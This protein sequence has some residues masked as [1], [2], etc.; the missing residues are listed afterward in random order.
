VDA[1]RALPAGFELGACGARRALAGACQLH[2]AAR[3]A[4]PIGSQHAY[5][6]EAEESLMRASL[7]QILARVTQ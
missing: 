4:C 5:D 6:L 7:D 2:C 3:R 1:P